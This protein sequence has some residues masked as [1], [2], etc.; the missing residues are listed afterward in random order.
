VLIE[1]WR[2]RAYNWIAFPGEGNCD[3]T[4]PA[5][6]EVNITAY[7]VVRPPALFCECAESCDDAIL[8]GL[9]SGPLGPFYSDPWPAC[10]PGSFE[11]GCEAAAQAAMAGTFAVPLYGFCGICRASGTL[12]FG[13]NECELGKWWYGVVSAGVVIDGVYDNG[14]L[15]VQQYQLSGRKASTANNFDNCSRT[16]TNAGSNGFYFPDANL[17]AWPQTNL[18]Y[19][20]RLINYLRGKSHVAPNTCPGDPSHT[21]VIA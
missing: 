20:K 10:D 11:C 21:V 1:D 13:Q 4:P 2:A 6:C 19:C 17:G 15:V 7:Y 9:V 8:L 16:T 3:C 14:D 12:G 5:Q 18:E